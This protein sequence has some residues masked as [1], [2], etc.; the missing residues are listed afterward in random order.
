MGGST[1]YKAIFPHFWNFENKQCS[2]THKKSSTY[3]NLIIRLYLKSLR[4][5][6]CEYVILFLFGSSY[7]V[8]YVFLKSMGA[9]TTHMDRHQGY[10]CEGKTLMLR[11]AVGHPFTCL[12]HTIVRVISSNLTSLLPTEFLEC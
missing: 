7:C 6:F 2:L 11:S 5:L 12:E 10:T 9:S 8:N 4:S 3:P 1:T